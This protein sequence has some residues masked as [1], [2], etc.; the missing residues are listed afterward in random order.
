[1]EP[2]RAPGGEHYMGDHLTCDVCGKVYDEFR[3]D[4][5]WHGTWERTI[6]GEST[7]LRDLCDSCHRTL[8]RKH[9]R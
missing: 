2:R 9:G 5:F 6:D 8:V 7:V 3:A 1:M 4:R